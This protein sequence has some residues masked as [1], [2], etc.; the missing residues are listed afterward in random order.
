[1]KIHVVVGQCNNKVLEGEKSCH[2]E[3][4]IGGIY[5]C[6]D[7]KQQ[8]IVVIS[9]NKL[10]QSKK[11]EFQCLIPTYQSHSLIPE[12]ETHIQELETPIPES[13]KHIPSPDA[14]TCP[15]EVEYLC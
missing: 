2:C 11:L 10:T 9:T 1:M 12:P 7:W 13:D 5:N 4:C 14:Q 3:N 8:T 6:R 15:F